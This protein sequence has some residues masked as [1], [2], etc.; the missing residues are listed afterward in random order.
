MEKRLYATLKIDMENIST[1]L[2]K[3]IAAVQQLES[4]VN[5]LQCAS[6]NI[7]VTLTEAFPRRTKGASTDCL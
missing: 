7:E 4:A 5:E 3:V 1:K 6:N 2:A